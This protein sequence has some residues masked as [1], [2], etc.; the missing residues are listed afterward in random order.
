MDFASNAYGVIDSETNDVG[1]T[2][3]EIFGEIGN[4]SCRWVYHM[5]NFEND[6][7]FYDDGHG[8]E[9]VWAALGNDFYSFHDLD[10]RMMQLEGKIIPPNLQD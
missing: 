4:D 2:D 3:C 7:S 1:G 6:A 5:N 10:N 8:S 9:S